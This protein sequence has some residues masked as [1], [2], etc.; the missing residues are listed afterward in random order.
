[1]IDLSESSPSFGTLHF[2]E[3][4]LGHVQRTQRLVL[5]ADVIIQHPAGTLPQ[6][7]QDPT[8]LDAFYRLANRKEVTHQAVFEPHRQRTLDQMRATT[9]PILVIHDTTEL[10]YTS[11]TSLTGLGQIGNGRGR[12]Y[13]CHHALAVHA[14]TRTVIGLANQILARRDHVPKN[15]SRAA[16]LARETRESRLWKL[17]SQA[18]GLAPEGA[19]WVDVCDR[20]A[21]IFEYLEYKHKTNGHY[22][23]RSKHDRLCTIPGPD[24]PRRGKLHTYARHLEPLGGRFVEV[25]AGDGQPARRATVLIAAGPVELVAPQQPRGDHGSDPLPLRLVVLRELDAPA[26]AEALE[27]ILLSDLPAGDL[28]E[29][30]LVAD[31]FGCRP[32]V[33]ELHK[34]M[35][36]GCGIETLQFTT[37]AALQ[38]AIALLSVVAVF[39]LGLRDAGR[40]PQRAGEPACRY[41]PESEVAVLSAWRHGQVRPGWTVGEFYQALGRLGGHQNRRSD[42]PPG[43]LVLSRGWSLLRAMVQGAAVLSAA[44]ALGVVAMFLLGWRDA[45]R[46]PQGVGPDAPRSAV[47]VRNAW[48]P[49]TERPGGTA[50]AVAAAPERWGGDSNGRSDPPPSGLVWNPGGSLG[51]SLVQGVAAPEPCQ[52]RSV[53]PGGPR[54][55]GLPS[56]E[57]IDSGFT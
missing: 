33:E 48:R 29:A 3:A 1:M 43:W 52:T 8:R 27:W 14:P 38:P 31:W 41:V 2:G 26:G 23:V 57:A 20:G 9:D 42:P 12:G 16:R 44:L 22:I 15:E 56:E 32:I 55:L 53:A 13:E 47:G 21:D 35:K 28:A 17:G 6:K 11:I 46:Q 49:S 18:V 51:P 50:G 25:A 36:T 37:E 54:S 7:F 19:T 45:G 39:L 40:D 30:S 10:D 5:S 34:G 4:R 24:G